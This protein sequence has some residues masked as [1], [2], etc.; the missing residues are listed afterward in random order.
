MDW[1]RM[2]PEGLWCAL[3]GLYRARQGRWAGSGLVYPELHL[4]TYIS[5]PEVPTPLRLLSS[6]SGM[7]VS[8]LAL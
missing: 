5:I 8:S 2:L 3:A 6:L 4:A 1:Y 7:D